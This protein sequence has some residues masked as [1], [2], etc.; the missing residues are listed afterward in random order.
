MYTAEN[1]VLRITK[2]G[3]TERDTQSDKN[4]PRV[5][6]KVSPLRNEDGRE[7]KKWIMII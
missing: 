7:Y 6:K 4:E 1:V 2:G 3:A 5:K